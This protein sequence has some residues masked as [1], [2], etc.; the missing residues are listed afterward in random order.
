MGVLLHVEWAAFLIA[1]WVYVIKLIDV[2]EFFSRVGE[3]LFLEG[4]I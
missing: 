1:R 3:L 2:I 4:V